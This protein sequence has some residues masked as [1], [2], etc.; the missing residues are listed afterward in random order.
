M[1]AVGRFRLPN[2]TQLNLTVCNR[3]KISDTTDI[4]ILHID[5]TILKNI[6]KMTYIIDVL[7][8]YFAMYVIFDII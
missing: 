5:L 1:Q 4:F 8:C 2:S 7:S 6:D 3:Y